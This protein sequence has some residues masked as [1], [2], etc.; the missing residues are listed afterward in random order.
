[1][2]LL[3]NF[4]YAHPVGHAVEALRY[5]LGYHAADEE[6]EISLLLNGATATELGS[7]C[8]FIRET[9]AVDYVDFL[10]R[11]G[12]PDAALRPV[13]RVWDY[14]L[15]DQRSR[16]PDQLEL[17]PGVRA[18]Y[19]A[20]HRHFRARV[21]HGTA[22]SE[23]PAYVPNQRLELELPGELR[24]RA[25]AEI[26]KAPV[27]IALMPAGSSEPAR[28]PSA[29]SWELIVRALAA[30]L[31]G[32]LFC[33]VGK[34]ERDGRTATSATRADLDRIAAAAPRAVSALDL[35][36]LEQLAY[37]ERCSLFLSP[38]TGFGTAALAVGTPW[39]ALSGGPWHEWLFNGVPFHSVIPDTRRYPAFTQFAPQ[40]DP[41]EDDGPRTPSMSR[42]R[43]EEDLPELVDA[44]RRLAEGRLTYEEALRAYFPRLLAAYGGDASRIFSF[45]SVHRAYI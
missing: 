15:D 10:G 28:Y 17:A 2:E 32:A 37:V 23:P 31:P 9:Y 41:V 20:A 14:V 30:D 26:G 38:H 21:C 6:L 25:R 29:A 19:Q 34:L 11:M 7:C 39:L 3:V 5:C 18:Y 13:P 33:F 8:P 16:Q 27:R 12:D 42:A 44:A 24:E 40:P 4:W 1:M 35:P 36:L 22:G 45:D 43:I